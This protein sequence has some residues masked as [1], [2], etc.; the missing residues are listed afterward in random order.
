[1]IRPHKNSD[2]AAPY[3]VQTQGMEFDSREEL[4]CCFVTI[5]F[6]PGMRHVKTHIPGMHKS[7]AS[8]RCVECFVR[9][10][11]MLVGRQYGCRFMS[12]SWRLEFRGAATFLENLFVSNG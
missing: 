8:R 1:M 12:F 10:R 5:A 2:M 7:R 3:G 4:N 11:L 6:S 9:R